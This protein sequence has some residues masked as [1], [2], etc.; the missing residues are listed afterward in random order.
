MSFGATLG[1]ALVTSFGGSSE[2]SFTTGDLSGIAGTLHGGSG[3]I[4]F[5][6]LICLI[7]IFH[8]GFHFPRD[9]AAALLKIPLEGVDGLNVAAKRGIHVSQKVESTIIGAEF[10]G[11]EEGLRGA[12]RVVLLEAAGAL[13]LLFRRC[14]AR[15]R[16]RCRLR[17][18][19]DAAE[20]DARRQRRRPSDRDYPHSVSYYSRIVPSPSLYGFRLFLAG[21]FVCVAVPA[22]S[23]GFGGRGLSG[24]RPDE[25]PI[26]SGPDTVFAAAGAPFVEAALDAAGGGGPGAASSAADVEALAE[27]GGRLG[28]GAGAAV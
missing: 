27:A 25:R 28:A 13:E 6:C 14:L 5:N 17:H 10:V 11:V 23:P 22:S 21:S 1:G 19:S 4:A 8:A 18:R 9:G 16:A 7:P 26:L 2:A 12:C 3:G 24:P 15:L 20:R